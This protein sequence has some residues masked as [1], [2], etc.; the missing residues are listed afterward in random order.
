[1]TEYEVRISK[2]YLVFPAA[3]FITYGGKCEPLHGHNYRTSV[4]VT[5]DLD[6]NHY[7]FD[8]VELKRITKEIVDELDHKTLLPRNNPGLQITEDEASVRVRY[9]DREYRFPRADVVLLP[10]PNTTAEMIAT[11][12]ARRLKEALARYPDVRLTAVAVEVEESFGQ[13]ARYRGSLL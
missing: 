8:F 5:G 7:V 9:Q 10:V 3:H 11:Y 12:I 1:M 13:S 6:E 4:V 2:D